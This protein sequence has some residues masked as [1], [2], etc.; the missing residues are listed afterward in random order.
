VCNDSGLGSVA[1]ERPDGGR[2]YRQNYTR[3][4]RLCVAWRLRERPAFS[5]GR[6]TCGERPS[7]ARACRPE[8][9]TSRCGS[10][11]CALCAQDGRHAL[12]IWRRK[13]L[14][15]LRLQRPRSIQLPPRWVDH[16]AHHHWAAPGVSPRFTPSQGRSYFLRPTRAEGFTRR[17]LSRQRSLRACAFLRRARAR[18]P[19]RFAVLEQTSF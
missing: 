3:A 18:R 15:W 16:P 7:K 17:N 2:H 8:G 14:H 13:T 5:P 1:P 6:C 9:K 11:S 4:F 10:P 12:P 19:P